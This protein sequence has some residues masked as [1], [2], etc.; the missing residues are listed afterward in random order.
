MPEVQ[1][2][3]DAEGFGFVDSRSFNDYFHMKTRIC[4]DWA[5]NG[6]KNLMGGR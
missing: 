5:D 4:R 3:S 2:I 6:K 1:Q